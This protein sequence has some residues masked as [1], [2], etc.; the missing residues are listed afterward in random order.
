MVSDHMKKAV[1]EFGKP[2]IN[3]LGDRSIYPDWVNV[4][5]V[6]PPFL[7]KGIDQHYYFGNLFYSIFAYMDAKFQYNDPS[8]ARRFLRLLT[9]PITDLF[10]QKIK[11]GT[12]DAE[13][14]QKLYELFTQH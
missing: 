9:D 3:L 11:K 4:W 12:F 13:L 6:F 1:A 10:F 2:G 14:N 5:D 8:Q 7:F